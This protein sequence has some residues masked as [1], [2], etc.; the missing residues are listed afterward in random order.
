MVLDAN[1]Q[2]FQTF[3]KDN[4]KVVVKYYADWCG[5]CRLFKPKFR[6]LSEEVRFSEVKFLDINAEESPEARKMA[7]VN[8]LPFFAVFKDG[9]FIEGFSTNKEEAVIELIEKL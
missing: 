5:G 4:A 7:N 6:R 2:D 8:N 1:D 9:K 3:L